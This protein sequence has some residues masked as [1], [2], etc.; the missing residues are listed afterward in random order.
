M[1]RHG[2]RLQSTNSLVLK[3]DFRTP[4]GFT[5]DFRAHIGRLHDEGIASER[6]GW[7]LTIACTASWMTRQRF[8]PF[9]SGKNAVAR[10]DFCLHH[11]T[12]LPLVSSGI[13]RFLRR[14]RGPPC[15]HPS[16][17]PSPPRR[18]T[19]RRS[20]SPSREYS[21]LGSPPASRIFARARRVV[22][23]VGGARGE[24]FYA[25]FDRLVFDRPSPP[26]PS[27]SVGS[28]MGVRGTKKHL[29][30]L[31]APKHWML[32]KLGGIFVRGETRHGDPKEK[33]GKAATVGCGTTC[34]DAGS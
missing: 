23:G 31:N 33:E 29:K 3:K 10:T 19:H 2:R 34:T 18:P 4:R 26:P 28:T 5:G 30:R 32:D 21:T 17:R 8:A 20:P 27:S 16:R 15:H 12:R 11:P 7:D 25:Q 22:W 6:F 9:V 14:W 13:P 24:V 1:S